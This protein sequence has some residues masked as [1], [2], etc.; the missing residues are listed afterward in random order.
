MIRVRLSAAA[1]AVAVL[2]L[3][4][5]AN[6]ETVAFVGGTV[7]PV[8]APEIAGGT[9]VVVDGKI[10]AVGAGIAVPAGAKVVACEGKHVYPGF[11][12]PQS[13]LGLTEVSSVRGTQDV[14]EVGD[15]NADARGEVAINPE[16]ELIPVA[17]ANGIT[18][19]M[20]CPRGGAIA[21]TAAMV[22]MDGWT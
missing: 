14:A 6:A 22:H 1:A 3:A 12:S 7:H 21:G 8:S 10:A 11:V 9:V 13:V 16:S 2:C 18:T 17:R 15:V 4:A 5:A 20:V 19:A